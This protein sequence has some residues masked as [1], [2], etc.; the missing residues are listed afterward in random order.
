MSESQPDQ[1]KILI[2]DDSSANMNLLSETLKPEKY[3]I[4]WAPNGEVALDIAKRIC[5][6]LILLDVLMPPG[7]DGFETCRRLKQEASIA[8][9]PVIFVTAKNETADLVQGFRVG[10]VDYITRP[11][12]EEEVLVRVRNHLKI[13][14]LTRE[15]AEQNRKLTLANE[16][17]QKEITKRQQAENEREQAKGALA[18]LSQQETS[19]WGIPGFIGQSKTI[20]RI[21]ADVRK[22]QSAGS[23]SVLIT[24]ES[25]TGKE[26][27]ARALH[28]GGERKEGP[29]ITVNC[30]AIPEDLAESMFFGHVKG[31][32]T[33]ADANKRGYFEV[34]SGGT[35]FLDEIGE[36]PFGLQVKLLRVLE[37]RMVMPVGATDERPVDVRVLAATNVNLQERVAEGTFREDLYYRLAVFPVVVPPLR[38]RQEDIPLLTDHF[39]SMFASE[40]NLE[41]PE[42]SSETMSLLATYH[43]PGNVRE[44]KNIIERALIQSGG[45][46]VLPQHLNLIAP[47]DA[48]Q[49]RPKSEL[50]RP[51][52]GTIELEQLE[53]LVIQRA[54]ARDVEDEHSEGQN[55]SSPTTDEEK[56]LEYI[57]QH[58]SITNTECRNLL[59]VDYHRASYLLKKMHR[60]GLLVREGKQRWARYRFP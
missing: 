28:Y 34:A 11:F 44:L 30:S 40:M 35:L 54:K 23:T 42:I 4:F 20:K 36:M 27:I 32:F 16:Q 50:Q 17:L 60:Y 48:T 25:G 2:V 3:E 24:G 14:Q 10:G 57:R 15:L 47:P 38:Q 9:I 18:H 46:V 58:G 8:E 45:S 55:G 29:F 56:I 59:S 37:S 13:N 21:L 39:L 19:R 12:E 22:L 31:A 53:S 7:I 1:P 6:D 5:P 41:R 43:F 33:G 51:D 52:E 49:Q 26:L